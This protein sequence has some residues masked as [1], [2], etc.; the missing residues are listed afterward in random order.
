MGNKQ[1]LKILIRLLPFIFSGEGPSL[2]PEVRTQGRPVGC[3]RV[4]HGDHVPLSILRPSDP[5]ALPASRASCQTH[6]GEAL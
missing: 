6:E 3:R 4:S 2:V 5:L 1:K